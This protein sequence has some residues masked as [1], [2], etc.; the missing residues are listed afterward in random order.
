VPQLELGHSPSAPP[1]ATAATSSS[2]RP[3]D[4]G[5]TRPSDGLTG[6][7]AQLSDGRQAGTSPKNG[8]SVAV[9]GKPTVHTDRAGGT[10]ARP[11]YVR[12]HRDTAPYNVTR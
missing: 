5:N 2:P 10:D 3:P 12:G 4:P 11:L 9:R 8:P 7:H 6:M 1:R